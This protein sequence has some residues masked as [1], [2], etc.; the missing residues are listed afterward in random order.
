MGCPSCGSNSI[1]YVS[2]VSAEICTACG[3]LVQ[4]SGNDLVDISE[5]QT[6]DEGRAQVTSSIFV[7]EGTKGYS[8]RVQTVCTYSSL[9][10]ALQ[11]A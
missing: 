10:T 3:T 1:E 5:A 7:G 11:R 6:Y 8:G 4:T 9:R 2:E